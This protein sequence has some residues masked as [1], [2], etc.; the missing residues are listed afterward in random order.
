MKIRIEFD[1]L[2]E[3]LRVNRKLIEA[4]AN[5]KDMEN[6]TKLMEV[7]YRIIDALATGKV[8][9]MVSDI[10]VENFVGTTVIPDS[11]KCGCYHHGYCWGTKELDKCDCGGR[12]SRCTF[13]KKGL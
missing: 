10:S 5:G 12:K 6:I 8:A 3:T 2:D 11:D 9:V 7:N 1:S 13:Y 4:L